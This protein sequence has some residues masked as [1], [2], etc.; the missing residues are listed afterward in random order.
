MTYLI[1]PKYIFKKTNKSKDNKWLFG[2]NHFPARARIFSY[3]NII[4]HMNA[5]GISGEDL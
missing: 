1:D 3:D 2:A 4:F 5:R